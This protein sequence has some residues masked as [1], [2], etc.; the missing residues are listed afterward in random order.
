[1]SKYFDTKNQT[2]MAPNVVEH[3]SHM[4]MTNVHRETKTKYVNIDTVFQQ[5]NRETD[6]KSSVQCKLP[7]PIT[8]VKSMKVV[9]G[10]IPVSFYNFSLQRKNTFFAYFRDFARRFDSL[11]LAFSLHL[12]RSPVL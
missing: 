12:L 4:I 8:N 11:P 5:D 2:F 1:M 6:C 7:Q 10:E 3:G 9:A